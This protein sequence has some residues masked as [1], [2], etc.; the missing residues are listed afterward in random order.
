MPPEEKAYL[1][2]G[3]D[4]GWGTVHGQQRVVARCDGCLKVG[5][6]PPER[7]PILCFRALRPFDS[8]PMRKGFI[9]VYDSR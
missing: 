5:G 7:H 4:I 1:S 9:G 8:T 3:W 6:G 2:S